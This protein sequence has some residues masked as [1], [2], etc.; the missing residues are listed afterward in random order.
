GL[1]CMNLAAPPRNA[2]PDVAV[3]PNFGDT[4]IN[5]ALVDVE[6]TAP[7]PRGCFMPR[8]YR[9]SANDAAGESS[10]PHRAPRPR[11]SRLPWTFTGVKPARC[12]GVIHPLESGVSRAAVKP[13]P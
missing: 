10:S 5:T 8:R 1:M 12:K 13:R 9:S 11:E 4:A 2:Q 3:I 7:I 6:R